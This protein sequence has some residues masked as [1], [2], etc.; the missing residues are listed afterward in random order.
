MS[1]P[2]KPN[3]KRTKLSSQAA[4]AK[5]V[6][7]QPTIQEI[8]D[9]NEDKLIEWIKQKKPDLLRDEDIEKFKTARISGEVFLGGAGNRKFFERAHLSFGVDVVLANL[10]GEIDKKSGYS[11]YIIDVTQTAS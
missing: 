3:P 7:N 11:F 4:Q 9:W 5:S 2:R 1:T 10:A 6:A 8:K